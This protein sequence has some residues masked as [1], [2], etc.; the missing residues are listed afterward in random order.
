MKHYHWSQLHLSC[1]RACYLYG[2]QPETLP[3]DATELGFTLHSLFADRDWDKVKELGF[4]S[5]TIQKLYD[6]HPDMEAEKYFELLLTDRSITEYGISGIVEETDYGIAGT[7]DLIYQDEYGVNIVDIKS[8]YQYR[9]EFTKQLE[10]Y[11]LYSYFNFPQLPITLWIYYAQRDEMSKIAM[12]NSLDKDRIQE[13]VI[14]AIERTQKI[15]QGELPKGEPCGFCEWCQYAINCP[16]VPVGVMDIRTDPVGVA[17]NY[18]L[19]KEK[20]KHFEK[21]LKEYCTELMIETD[22]RIIGY[23]T[24]QHLSIDELGAIKYL[25]DNGIPTSEILMVSVIKY[26]NACKS[27]TEL[28]NYAEIKEEVKFG[29]KTREKEGK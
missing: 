20:M 25:A 24:S 27:Y 26:R 11:A 21:I 16:D 18:L 10:E 19:L 29:V 4:Q 5:E 13:W 2:T 23:H 9:P 22:D 7:I 15:E 12:L 6:K 1:E 28:A 3:P 14:K 17:N 8:A